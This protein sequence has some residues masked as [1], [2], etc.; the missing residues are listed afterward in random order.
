M[1]YEMEAPAVAVLRDTSRLVV[2][3]VPLGGTVV[4]VSTRARMLYVADATTLLGMPDLTA[5]AL[6]V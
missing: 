1:V 3:V 5:M 2:A 6:M 4:G